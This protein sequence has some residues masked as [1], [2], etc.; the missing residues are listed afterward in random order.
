MGFSSLE[1]QHIDDMEPA[2]L[3]ALLSYAYTSILIISQENVQVM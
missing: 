1:K 2:T 3:E